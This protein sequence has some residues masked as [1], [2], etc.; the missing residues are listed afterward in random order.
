MTT[1]RSRPSE[2]G[3][4]KSTDG[5]SRRSCGSVEVQTAQVQ[6]S[7]GTPMEVP[8]P[9]N[10]RTPSIRILKRFSNLGGV[11]RFLQGGSLLWEK[12]TKR[13]RFLSTAIGE[14]LQR[15]APGGGGWGGCM[16]CR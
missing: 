15:L 16:P 5:R 9:R 6:P 11:S 3:Q 13:L 7:V 2:P 14:L 12:A 1:T 4:R 10:V 8:V